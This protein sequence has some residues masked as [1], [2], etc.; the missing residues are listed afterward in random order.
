MQIFGKE[1]DIKE[2]DRSFSKL[3]VGVVDE[4]RIAFIAFKMEDKNGYKFL[5]QYFFDKEGKPADFHSGL[6]SGPTWP[7]NKPG[8]VT[9]ENVFHFEELEAVLEKK[10]KINLWK[11]LNQ[12]A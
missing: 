1:V 7:S 8:V 10:A 5:H 12:L 11:S 6:Y 3:A 4:A 2:G 9:K